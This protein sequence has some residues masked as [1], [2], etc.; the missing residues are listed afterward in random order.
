MALPNRDVGAGRSA[1]AADAWQAPYE[2]ENRDMVLAYVARHPFL[3]PLLERAPAAIARHFGDHD[4]LLLE[5]VADPDSD[6]AEHLY[7]YVLTRGGVEEVL[8]RRARLDDG[9][10]ID[11][12]LDARGRMT[13]DV[14]PG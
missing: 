2:F 7:L 5:V 12:M 8:R 11:A 14:G 6:G 1:S 9:W 10:W 4:D 13:V 3:V